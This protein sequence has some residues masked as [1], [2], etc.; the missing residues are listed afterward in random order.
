MFLL[1][2]QRRYQAQ[3]VFADSCR[4]H[5]FVEAFMLQVDAVD[6]VVEFK[7]QEAALTAGFLQM[8]QFFAGLFQ[9]V[10]P[11]LL[12]IAGQVFVQQLTSA[13]AAAQQTGWPPKVLPWEPMVKALETSS[14]AQMAAIGMPPPRAFAMETISGLMP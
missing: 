14:R 11:H 5:V 2:D 1:E 3:D 9:E 13:K 10:C 6:L 12:G 8:R 7:P 4:Q